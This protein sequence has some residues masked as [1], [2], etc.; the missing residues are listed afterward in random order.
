MEPTIQNSSINQPMTPAPLDPN[1]APLYVEEQPHH[2]HISRMIIVTVFV[3][4]LGIVS[5][6]FFQQSNN[7]NK[8]KI[9]DNN[10]PNQQTR[11]QDTTSNSGN[12][13]AA[14]VTI[15]PTSTPAP[16]AKKGIA[17][18]TKPWFKLITESD[19]R[20]YAQGED[21]VIILKGFSE[22]NDI[23]GYDVLLQYDKEALDIISVESLPRTFEIRQISKNTHLTI[24]GYK[25]ITVNTPTIFNDDSLVKIVARGKKSG[26]TA[27]SLLPDVKKEKTKMVDKQ[28][29]IIAPQLEGLEVEI[30]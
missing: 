27:L 7:A 14:R 22:N 15:P 16:L 30:Q 4:L 25:D 20:P 18:E 10:Q 11:N 24:T 1:T 23:N 28:V 17:D 8:S 26:T 9:P 3:L 6:I 12:A 5:F 21:I 19:P 29:R 2:R 13:L